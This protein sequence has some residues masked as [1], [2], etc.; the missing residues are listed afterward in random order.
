[1]CLDGEDPFYSKTIA[2]WGSKKTK[3]QK[4]IGVFASDRHFHREI[5]RFLPLFLTQAKMIRTD[6]EPKALKP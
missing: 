5:R 1:M 6:S 2:V 3:F 4:T